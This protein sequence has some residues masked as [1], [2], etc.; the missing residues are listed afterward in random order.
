MYHISQRIIPSSFSLYVLFISETVRKHVT[1][2][3]KQRYLLEFRLK[4]YF[5]FPFKNL[6]P[7][8][9]SS[10]GIKNKNHY[11]R[12]RAHVQKAIR[13]AYWKHIS[14]IFSFETDDNDPDCPR[15]NEKYKKFWSIV[16]SL[17]KIRQG[18]LHLEKAEF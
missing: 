4:V 2:C 16:K 1:E 9:S 17:K 10:P 15:K 3:R 7:R 14:N 18:S 11:E 13:D 8:K 6:K 12:F 5:I